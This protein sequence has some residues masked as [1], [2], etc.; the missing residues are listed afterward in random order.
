MG[1]DR[2]ASYR[3]GKRRTGYRGLMSGLAFALMVV[4]T[5]WVVGSFVVLR[6]R[7]RLVSEALASPENIRL[8][9]QAERPWLLRFGLSAE[10]IAGLQDLGWEIGSTHLEQAG[11]ASV[12]TVVLFSPEGTIRATVAVYATPARRRPTSRSSAWPSWSTT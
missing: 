11:G 9:P 4:L 3:R 6:R 12:P 5:A 8:A 1:E 7:Q 10:W 2:D